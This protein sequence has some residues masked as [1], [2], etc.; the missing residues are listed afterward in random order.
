MEKY[1]IEYRNGM[2]FKYEGDALELRDG[3]AIIYVDNV[4]V[5]I[6]AEG[7]WSSAYKEN[8]VVS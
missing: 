7:T 5:V 1:V 6:A 3:A 2:D 8:S 4:P